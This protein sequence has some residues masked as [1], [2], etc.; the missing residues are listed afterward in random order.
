MANANTISKA[1][2]FEQALSL[3]FSLHM[4]VQ[5]NL[6]SIKVSDVLSDKQHFQGTRS[7]KAIASFCDDL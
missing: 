2:G 4:F 3:L 1:N 7:I 5:R 6:H